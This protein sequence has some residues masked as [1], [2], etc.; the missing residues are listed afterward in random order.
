MYVCIINSLALSDYNEI[1]FGCSS[2]DDVSRCHLCYQF[3]LHRFVMRFPAVLQAYNFL[4]KR[5]HII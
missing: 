4:Q 3:L 2:A 5:V 1:N